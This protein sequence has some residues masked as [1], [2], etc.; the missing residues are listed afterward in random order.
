MIALFASVE[1]VGEAIHATLEE[2]RVLRD[3]G[4]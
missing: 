3:A 2:T 1:N 4:F